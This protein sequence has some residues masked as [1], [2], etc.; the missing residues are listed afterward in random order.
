MHTFDLIPFLLPAFAVRDSLLLSAGPGRQMSKLLAYAGTILASV[1]SAAT[2]SPGSDQQ[3]RFVHGSYVVLAT[4]LFYGASL[5]LCI[6]VGRTRRRQIAWFIAIIPNPLLAF[7]LS[8]F[9]RGMFPYDSLFFSGFATAV[10]TGVWLGLVFL[11][12]SATSNTSQDVKEQDW[13]VKLAGFINS[14]VLMIL[15]VASFFDY[16]G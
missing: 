15:P 6:W 13:S 7:V 12:V 4:V 14:A 11:S 2:L 5:A 8:S 9:S 1:F 10:T 3:L 16:S